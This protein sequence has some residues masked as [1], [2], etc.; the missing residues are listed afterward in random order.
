MRMPRNLP[1]QLGGASAEVVASEIA[2]EQANT[3]SRLGGRLHDTLNAL[4]AFDAAH[5]HPS[6]SR[7]EERA[8]LVAAAA[9]ALWYYVV[10]REVLGLGNS[11]ALMRELRIPPEVRL[12]MGTFPRRGAP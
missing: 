1:Q 6:G 8:E 3:L 4:H 2:Q 5:P 12:R 11:E 10:Q 7:G 9:Q